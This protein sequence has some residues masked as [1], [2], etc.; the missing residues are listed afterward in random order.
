MRKNGASFKLLLLLIIFSLTGLALSSSDPKYPIEQAAQEGDTKLLKNLL[1]KGQ[2]QY[3]RD[4]ALRFSIRAGH[5]VT[6]EL[7]VSH[8]ARFALLKA[9]EEGN[10]QF[11]KHFLD[12]GKK[13]ILVI[14]LCMGPS[15]TDINR[16]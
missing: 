2:S 4:S 1:T 10:I 8:G 14:Q 3:L 7:L 6:A 5:I 16:L 11:V 13:R 9:A 12:Q 15:E